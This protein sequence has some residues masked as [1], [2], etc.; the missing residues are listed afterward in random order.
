MR[1]MSDLES[2]V[3]LRS[4]LVAVALRW[5]ERFGVAPSVTSALSELDAA[6]LIGMTEEKYCSDCAHRTAV[7]AGHDFMHKGCRYQV[8]ANR[9]SG[10]PGSFVTLVGKA[11]NHDWDKLIWI[12]YDQNYVVREAWEWEVDEYVRQFDNLKRLSP[13][14]MRQGRRLFPQFPRIA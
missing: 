5:Q 9:P 10:R 2:A 8:K 3:K 7:T 1:I 11:N 13:A 6:L 12:L 14:H 4:E